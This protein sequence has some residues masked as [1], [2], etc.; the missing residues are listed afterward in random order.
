[1]VSKIQKFTEI[2]F[3]TN[4]VQSYISGCNWS[5]ISD[6]G[7]NC[8]AVYRYLPIH[9]TYLENGAESTVK[10]VFTLK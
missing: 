5:K 7:E 6:Q 10:K 8:F 1:M 9:H 3:F 4:F 2:F